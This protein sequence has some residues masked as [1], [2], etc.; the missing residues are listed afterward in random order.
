MTTTIPVP[1][2]AKP[3]RATPKAMAPTF[4]AALIVIVGTFFAY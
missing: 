4:A 1:K 2:P 3:W